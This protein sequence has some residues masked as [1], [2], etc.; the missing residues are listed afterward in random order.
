MRSPA[1]SRRPRALTHSSPRACTQRHHATRIL[2]AS[3]GA[4]R[5]DGGV[6]KLLVL[7][8]SRAAPGAS[9]PARAAATTA[10][11][12]APHGETAR[13][14]CPLAL[15]RALL[16]LALAARALL[17]AAAC[18]VACCCVRCC[19]LARALLVRCCLLLLRIPPPCCCCISHIFPGAAR[20]SMQMRRHRTRH[21]QFT[22]LARAMSIAT[23][24]AEGCTC[25]QLFFVC[26][27]H[28]AAS[29]C[30]RCRWALSRRRRPP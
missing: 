11:S 20:V 12:P 19:L 26:A 10:P 4:D 16:P 17:L 6:N 15:L 1:P 8:S 18:A 25:C 28:H 7:A 2:R 24:A 30:R 14:L 13:A 5:R 21:V 27:Q 22:T 9:R 3:H 23:A 29:E